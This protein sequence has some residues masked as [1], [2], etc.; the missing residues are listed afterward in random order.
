[1]N[2]RVLIL[3][4]ALCC[5]ALPA[6]AQFVDMGTDPGSVR[7]STRQGPNFKLYFPEQTDSIAQLYLRSL[8][9][10]RPLVG[11]SIGALPNEMYRR[12][13]TT[14]L[15]PF[16]SDSN[17]SVS[18]APR[19][20]D[21]YALPS[22]YAPEPFPWIDQLTIHESRHVSQMQ[23]SR[24]GVFN[25]LYWF[26]GQSATAV[27]L[28]PYGNPAFLEGDAVT[29]ETALTNSGRGRTADF[30]EYMQVAFD[31]GDW[32]DW[33][34]WRYGAQNRY[35]P[36]YYKVGYMTVAGYRTLYDD[37]L[38][39]K[40]FYDN[41]FAGRWRLPLN[42]LHKT[43]AQASDAR[44]KD[45]FRQ[46]QEH[47]QADWEKGYAERGPFM[48]AE[49]LTDAPRL[50]ES[51][52]SITVADG[53]IYALRNGI[54]RNTELVELD[55]DGHVT[56]LCYHS[57][58][59]SALRWSA[60]TGRLLWSE[61]VP[62]RRWSLAGTVRIAW[63][64]PGSSKSGYLTRE[65]RLFNPAPCP[66]DSRIS[67][68][69]L[70]ADGS[71]AVLVLDARDGRELTRIEAP[72][73]FQVVET[74]WID[75]DIIASCI[76]KDGIGLYRAGSWECILPPQPVK[77]KQ[78]QS[79][80]EGELLFVSDRTGVNELYSLRSGVLRQMTN[81]RYGAAD[82]ARDDKALYFS[83]L[84]KEGRGIY[85]APLS[86]LPAKAVNWSDIHHYAIADELSA[87]EK[88]LGATEG[89]EGEITEQKH[90]SKLANPLSI[91]SW[92]PIYLEYDSV[93]SLSGEDFES[94]I[95]LGSSLYFQ[96]RLGTFY[97]S[98][99]I[100][101]SAD[102][103]DNGSTRPSG[104]LQF[105]YEGLYPVLEADVSAGERDALTYRLFD[106]KGVDGRS[107]II[108]ASKS[109]TP[110][111]S[112]DLKA[113]IPLD[114]SRGPWNRG[115]IPTATLYLSN[116]RFDTGIWDMSYITAL[117]EKGLADSWLSYNGF[118]PGTGVNYLSSKFALRGYIILSTPSSCIFPR[119]G[120]GTEAG[121]LSRWG[122]E[123]VYNRNV[124]LSLYGY[125]PGLMR[126]HGLRLS[127][128]VQHQIGSESAFMHVNGISI[129]PRGLDEDNIITRWTA[130]RYKTQGKV[131]LEYAMPVLP[132]G[133]NLGIMYLRNFELHPFADLVLAGGDGRH[134]SL[135]S[136]GII[137][138][139]RL[140]HFFWLPFDTTGGLTFA[141][142]G[143]SIF[144][145]VTAAGYE[146]QRIYIGPSFNMTF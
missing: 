76:S 108:T 104:H 143:G 28:V 51:Y 14:L 43:A 89:D 50:Y 69:S 126:T 44:F 111:V 11:A 100:A 10:Y 32:R 77:I 90:Y 86:S 52:T 8:E 106:V 109:S 124:Y 70:P 42:I 15:H 145:D 64:E 102:T 19:R 120:I 26:F 96:N 128:V 121:Y 36:D 78:L 92:M 63:W 131:A 53:H 75:G 122:L 66:S 30:L 123:K 62:D 17:G 60:G 81:T 40:R 39:T 87:Q 80:A 141:L 139:A 118:S 55:S 138:K 35:T 114:L 7:W 85:I 112:A 67:V 117:S 48:Q 2:K 79:G 116:D 68:T 105:T 115:V 83:G 134:G 6:G 37:P 59:G 107:H 16:T 1:M 72:G 113:Y 5:M 22:P 34:R 91:H 12:P 57:S 94:L 38:F 31:S 18:W 144:D 73:E 9:K 13:M 135:Y 24:R 137:V 84:T 93:S 46:V 58:Y 45:S 130:A 125:V 54:A 127:A 41:I 61:E 20:M 4:T 119:W 140:G 95:H 88:A 136:T 142:N 21:L 103:G 65:G 97:G 29:A 133:R 99:G 82:F 33:Y 3:V 132:V 47:F 129:A 56:H 23:F 25:K 146:P 110:L 71:S 27:L 49:T 74:A 98:A 101:I